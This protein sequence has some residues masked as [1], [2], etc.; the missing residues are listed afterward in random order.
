[1]RHTRMKTNQESS[2]QY[3]PPKSKVIMLCTKHQI[4]QVSNQVGQWQEG[5]HSEGGDMN[6][7]EW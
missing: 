3:V 1:M 5:S 7:G 6:D 2:E 4:M